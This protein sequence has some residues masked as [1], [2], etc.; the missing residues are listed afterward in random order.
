MSLI[1]PNY[2]H[3]IDQRDI[4]IIRERYNIIMDLSDTIENDRKILNNLI[5]LRNNTERRI[6]LVSEHINTLKKEQYNLETNAR[7]ELMARFNDEESL[8]KPLREAVYK[9]PVRALGSVNY[10]D[11]KDG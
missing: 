1:S 6:K 4:N 3:T 2:I 11:I 9:E 10:K 8:S 5:N 7:V